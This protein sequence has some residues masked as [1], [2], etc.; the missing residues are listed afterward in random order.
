MIQLDDL[1]QGSYQPFADALSEIIPVETRHA[2]Y[3][4]EGLR[5]APCRRLRP[6]RRAGIRQILVSRVAGNVRTRRFGALADLSPVRMRPAGKRGLLAAW[7]ADVRSILAGAGIR[8][9]GVTANTSREVRACLNL[10]LEESDDIRDHPFRN[11]QRHR[12]PDAESPGQA[13]QLQREID[14]EVRTRSDAIAADKRVRVGRADRRRPRFLR[15]TGPVRSRGGSRRTPVDLGESIEKYY[16]PLVKAI[17]ALPLPVLC[18]VNGVA[19]RRRANIALCLRHRRRDALGE[20]HRAVLPA[21]P[22]SRHRRYVFPATPGRHR[23]RNGLALFGDKLTAEQ[24]RR[25]GLIWK[26][27]DDDTFLLRSTSWRSTFRPA[28][29]K[30]LARTKQAIYASSGNSLASS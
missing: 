19:A 1:S 30:G 3:G 13:Q 6:D 22:P 12:P 5:T 27:I 20:L 24:G 9:P 17:R 15:G 11:R 21:G 29:T 28:P 16:G 2:G 23:A 18:A 10:H 7:K 26:C 4:T 14:Q 25:L 8:E